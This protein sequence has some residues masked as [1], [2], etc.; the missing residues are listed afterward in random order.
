M[1]KF[2]SPP[3]R[4]APVINAAQHSVG[5][6]RLPLPNSV[7]QEQQGL[8]TSTCA[9]IQFNQLSNGE[10]I[11]CLATR[12]PDFKRIDPPANETSSE[13][14]HELLVA[15]AG[16]SGIDTHSNSQQTLST[17]S[18]LS[19]VRMSDIAQ[20][21]NSNRPEGHRS[22]QYILDSDRAVARL[23]D[24]YFEFANGARFVGL[25]IV[26]PWH[27]PE[28]G[29]SLLELSKQCIESLKSMKLVFLPIRYTSDLF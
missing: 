25:D 29:S 7:C 3:I 22:K 23:A 9:L 15:E 16:A 14:P 18:D 24:A 1:A 19:Q 10:Q 4:L 12:A 2:D 27:D 20:D 26:A 5:L 8:C 13:T 17:I 21:V 28:F 11:Y 6:V